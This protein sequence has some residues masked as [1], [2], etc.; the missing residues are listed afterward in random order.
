M[1]TALTSLQG[2]LLTDP[3]RRTDVNIPPMAMYRKRTGDVKPSPCL[4]QE[5]M[6]AVHESTHDSIPQTHV[7]AKRVGGSAASKNAYRR[8]SE[9]FRLG[10]RLR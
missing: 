6:E 2:A 7:S 1:Q 4:M 3:N 8:R 9:V 10:F 5:A